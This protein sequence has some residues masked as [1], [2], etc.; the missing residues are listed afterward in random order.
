[1]QLIRTPVHHADMGQPSTPGL[2]V[3]PHTAARIGCSVA[4]YRKC[5]AAKISFAN[6]DSTLHGLKTKK[7]N[8]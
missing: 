4:D 6:W 8:K 3:G 5:G 7:L 2:S 1:M